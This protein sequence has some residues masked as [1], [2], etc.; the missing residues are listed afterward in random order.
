MHI[1]GPISVEENHVPIENI[2]CVFLNSLVKEGR[3][4]INYEHSLQ[5]QTIRYPQ[6]RE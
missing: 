5:N 3:G 6:R 4:G 2:V 1:S